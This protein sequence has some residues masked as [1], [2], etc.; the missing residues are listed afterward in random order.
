MRILM[1]SN[2]CF[3]HRTKFWSNG[4]W[5][6]PLPQGGGTVVR[7]REDMAGEA[8][9]FQ[10]VPAK[11]LVDTCKARDKRAA[12]VNIKPSVNF[13]LR[14]SPYIILNLWMCPFQFSVLAHTFF[15]F[16]NLISS[17]CHY[18]EGKIL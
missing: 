10:E 5:K 3:S 2:G 17:Y 13:N 16:Q 8:C 4:R 1:A 18:C 9:N 15:I 7:R 6:P 11:K 14:S 12:V